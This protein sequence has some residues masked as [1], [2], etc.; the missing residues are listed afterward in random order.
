MADLFIIGRWAP[1]C[2]D[3]F[4][5][6]TES[7]ESFQKSKAE[8]QK[9]KRRGITEAQDESVSVAAKM[10]HHSASTVV[11]AAL[12]LEA[13]IYDY[14]AAYF[15][16]THARKYLQGID[17]VSKWVVI[18]KL[19][20]GKDFPTEGRAFEHLVKLRK[21]RNDL[22]H[23][24]SRPLPTNIKEWEELQAETEREDDANAVNAYQTVK[25]VLTELHKLEG[26]GKWNQWWRYS[27]T[28]KR[29]KTISKLRQV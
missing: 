9:I 24:K 14:A 2:E 19:V 7:Y 13:F 1:K 10:R 5:I 20:T 26:R 27:P 23:Y 25:E 8:L 15:T 6:C 29:A 12:C 21:A 22:V 4:D 28:K 11:F 3:F 16:D 17:F 18:P